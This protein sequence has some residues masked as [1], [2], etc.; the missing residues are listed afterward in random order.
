MKMIS[1]G[2]INGSI[3]QVLKQVHIHWVKPQTIL[4]KDRIMVM[5]NKF[6]SWILQCSSLVNYVTQ[7]K[8]DA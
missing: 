3:D 6:D 4:D 7:C 5:I 1:L 2:R 8:E